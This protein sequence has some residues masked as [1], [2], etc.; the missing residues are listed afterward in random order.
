VSLIYAILNSSLNTS[1]TRGMGSRPRLF[2]L[3]EVSGSRSSCDS[4][5]GACLFDARLV[6]G[7]MEI[8]WRVL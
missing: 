8:F 5:K 4:M 3:R 1:M 7:D 2:P 6:N